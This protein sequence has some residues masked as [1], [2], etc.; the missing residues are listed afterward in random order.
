MTWVSL[1]IIS[2]ICNIYQNCSWAMFQKII[3]LMNHLKSILFWNLYWLVQFSSLQSKRNCSLDFERKLELSSH[4]HWIT[5]HN[6]FTLTFIKFCS[7]Q[8]YFMY[9]LIL[10]ILFRQF[11]YFVFSFI[12]LENYKVEADYE[13]NFI[14]KISVVSTAK[15]SLITSKSACI[16]CS[17]G[18]NFILSFD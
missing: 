1:I 17:R 15:L 10:C 7:F 12:L 14:F 11:W 16:S 9:M 13:N 6:G 5:L 18:P 3:D 2:D 4:K 8:L